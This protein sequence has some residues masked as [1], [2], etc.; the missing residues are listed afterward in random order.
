MQTNFTVGVR[1]CLH[2]NLFTARLESSAAES[3]KI[4][5][6]FSRRVLEPRELEDLQVVQL[7]S[8]CFL[9]CVGGLVSSLWWFYFCQCA[10]YRPRSWAASAG[11][12]N[13][14]E[15]RHTLSKALALTMD[16]SL[17]L[18]VLSAPFEVR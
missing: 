9:C 6:N 1:G 18:R 5:S 14:H 10:I 16:G 13:V 17:V 8:S 12:G 4:R 3:V 11:Q 15:L 2:T 7:N